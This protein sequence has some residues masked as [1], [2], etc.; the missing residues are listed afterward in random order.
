MT[1][2]V[3]ISGPITGVPNFHEIF[4]EAEDRLISAG[5]EVVNPAK[6]IPP[7]YHACNDSKHSWI[8]NMRWD[9][10]AMLQECD[11]IAMLPLWTDSKGAIVEFNLARGLGFTAKNLEEWIEDPK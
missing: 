2:K 11:K 10:I 7:Y 5:Y 6:V 9:L 1:N 4:Q 8:C 3:Y